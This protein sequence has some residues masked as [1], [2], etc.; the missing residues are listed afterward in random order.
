MDNSALI[1][2]SQEVYE[3]LQD[4]FASFRISYDRLVEMHHELSRASDHQT[5]VLMLDHEVLQKDISRFSNR[6]QILEEIKNVFYF[7][8]VS[9]YFFLS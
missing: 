8:L 9:L 4:R 3:A 7:N 2:S 5:S 1:K 6:L